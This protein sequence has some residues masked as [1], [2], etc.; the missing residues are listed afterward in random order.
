MQIW[1]IS[2]GSYSLKNCHKPFGK[3]IQPPP[4]YGKMP[5]EHLKSFPYS[6]VLRRTK[7][8]N[9]CILVVKKDHVPFVPSQKTQFQALK[10]A[11]SH[12]YSLPSSGLCMNDTMFLFIFYL[13]SLRHAFT[14][15]LV[16]RMHAVICLINY[17]HIIRD[18]CNSRLI[19]HSSASSLCRIFA[20]LIILDPKFV[21]Y[22]IQRLKTSYIKAFIGKL[23]R[24]DP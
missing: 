21:F 16:L 22:R 9:L 5:V 20:V 17:S 14:Q 11:P 15:F 13:F 6:L 19:C 8:H 24:G 10:S 4:P 1:F 3:A 2:N 23:F 7:P 18:I 12:F